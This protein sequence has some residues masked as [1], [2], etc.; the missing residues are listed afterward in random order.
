[1]K[2][3]ETNQLGNAFAQSASNTGKARQRG[4]ETAKTFLLRLNE[5]ERRVLRSEAGKLP[6][7]TYISDTGAAFAR[8]L[9][10]RGYKLAQGD[11]RSFVAVDAHGEVYS[12][13]R[14]IDLKTKDL[15]AR[16]GDETKLV[17]VDEAKKQFVEELQPTM[18]RLR[19]ELLEDITHQNRRLHEQSTS[20]VQRHRQA[21]QELHESLERRQLEA[22]RVAAVVII[23][24]LPPT[25]GP[26]TVPVV[27]RVDVGSWARAL[28][29]VDLLPL[30]IACSEAVPDA[31]RRFTGASTTAGLR[32]RPFDFARVE[33]IAA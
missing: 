28:K 33:R 19:G 10:E 29:I 11:R 18:L 31:R 27:V 24:R 15:R 5:D 25:N 20:M 6:L 1:M 32:P 7:G 14:W 9:E 23:S 26:H 12:L 22:A 4:T 3:A 21:R 8:A 17:T 16:V 2:Q 30:N 13:H